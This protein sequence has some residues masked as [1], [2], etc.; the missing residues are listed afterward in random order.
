MLTGH[1]LLY[2]IKYTTKFKE[3]ITIKIQKIVS[4]FGVWAAL[5]YAVSYFDLHS[6]YDLI[7]F[8]SVE[9]SDAATF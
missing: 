2:K 3:I 9:M 7:F 6:Y 8:Q 5:F 4:E 1:A